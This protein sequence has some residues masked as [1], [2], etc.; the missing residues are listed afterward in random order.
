M[1]SGRPTYSPRSSSPRQ[2]KPQH[3]Q[4]PLHLPHPPAPY[5]QP[6]QHHVTLHPQQ[7]RQQHPQLPP[8]ADASYLAD[9]ISHRPRGGRPRAPAPVYGGTHD[10]WR[11]FKRSL[12]GRRLMPIQAA[13]AAMPV[14]PPS[15]TATPSGR[16]PWRRRGFTQASVAGLL[17]DPAEA[18]Q[19]EAAWGGAATHSPRRT[20]TLPPPPLPGQPYASRPNTVEL[21]DPTTFAEPS[22]RAR[23]LQLARSLAQ[24]VGTLSTPGNLPAAL[25]PRA[26]R[27]LTSGGGGG[28]GTSADATV[29]QHELILALE[30]ADVV[31]QMRAIDESVTALVGQVGSHCTEQALLLEVR[32]PPQHAGRTSSLSSPSM[33][34]GS[35][36]GCW[37]G[38]RS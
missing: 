21:L 19:I 28:G 18:S 9:G 14:P 8:T 5:Q 3:R 33:S 17:F 22:G 37:R 13:P 6:R 38:R 31:P 10:D 30:H 12:E 20:P 34:A 26:A 11:N 16:S 1:S 36:R 27:A 4:Q 35:A 7:K 24:D 29:E 25:T 15:A 32:P 23:A 2:A